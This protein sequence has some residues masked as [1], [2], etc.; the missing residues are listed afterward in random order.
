LGNEEEGRSAEA[1]AAL[2]FGRDERILAFVLSVC[3]LIGLGFLYLRYF[4]H[5]TDWP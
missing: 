1:E 5:W 2:K 4:V 3:A